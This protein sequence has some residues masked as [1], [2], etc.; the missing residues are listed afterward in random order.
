MAVAAFTAL[1]ACASATITV[2]PETDFTLR[3][4]EWAQLD[5]TPLSVQ[6]DTISEDSRCPS[7][8]QCVWAGNA[9]VQ[10]R[11]RTATAGDAVMPVNTMLDPRSAS[12][13]G[14]TVTLVGVEPQPRQG[15]PIRQEDYRV[16]LRFTQ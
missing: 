13:G 4:K 11:M 14:R 10:L 5:G 7:D 6:V 12:Y 3:V 1:A 8:V 2:S 15:Q 9:R 16:R